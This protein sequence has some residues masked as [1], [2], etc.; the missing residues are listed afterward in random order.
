MEASEIQKLDLNYTAEIDTLD[1]VM[2]SHVLQDFKDASIYQTWSYGKVVFGERNASRLVLKR[3][4]EIVGIAQARIA[5]LPVVNLGIAYVAWGPLWRRKGQGTDGQVFRQALR[6]LRNEFSFKRGLVLRVFPHVLADGTSSCTE[7]L[8]EEGF[9][10]MA[11]DTRGRTI[12]MDLNPP[13]LELRE[14]MN[15]HWKR[16]LKIAEKKNLQV[17]EG[18]DD[19]LFATFM[20]MYK[21]MV[22]RKRFVEPNDI[23]QFR[24]I[25]SQLPDKL[26]MKILLCRSSEGPCAGVICS[27]IGASAVYL[28]G[29][30]SNSGMKSNG[31]Y[32][33]QW[34]LIEKLKSEG[35]PTYNLNGINPAKNPG[36]YKFKN[37]LAGRNGKDVYYL[38]R[39]DTYCSPVKY[40]CIGWGD[41]LRAA[42]RKA[43]GFAAGLRGAKLRPKAVKTNA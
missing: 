16:E 29:A 8:A 28:F 37:D 43:K 18:S 24:A 20:E 36:T 9:A 2:W 23:K 14:G 32:L 17:V 15:S 39:F 5:K 34:K 1:E 7:I 27:A 12:M 41:T 11:A 22:S 21:E 40:A 31:S 6:A 19:E 4:G 33:L 30:T 10:S 26:K 35:I 3:Q 38:G 25:Q 42:L 13:L